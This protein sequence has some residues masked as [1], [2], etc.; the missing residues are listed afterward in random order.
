[1]C[2][3]SLCTGIKTVSLTVTAAINNRWII[4]KY[5]LWNKEIKI[6]CIKPEKILKKSIIFLPLRITI[7]M[8]MCPFTILPVDFSLNKHNL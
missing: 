5:K 1:M 6:G 4:C 7:T 2:A 8:V 3:V